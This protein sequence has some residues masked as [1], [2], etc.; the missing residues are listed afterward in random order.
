MLRVSGA[1]ATRFMEELR[2]AGLTPSSSWDDPVSDLSSGEKQRAIE[3][4]LYALR[5]EL[6]EVLL[7]VEKHKEPK[8]YQ[9]ISQKVLDSFYSP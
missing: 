7:P 8:E 2:L 9:K 4:F 3:G 6:A 5:Y 1:F